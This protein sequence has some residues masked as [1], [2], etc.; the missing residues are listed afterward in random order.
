MNELPSESYLFLC[1]R[2]G[3]GFRRWNR[4]GFFFWGEVCL[5]LKCWFRNW[6]SSLRDFYKTCTDTCLR[7]IKTAC[8]S[9]AFPVHIFHA[10]NDHQTWGDDSW[11]MREKIG[12]VFLK[13]VFLALLRLTLRVHNKCNIYDGNVSGFPVG[14]RA[15][16]LFVGCW[17]AMM[18]PFACCWHKPRWN[19]WPRVKKCHVLY[20]NCLNPEGI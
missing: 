5:F 1:L 2:A 10:Q 19:Y 20:F 15:A 12:L 7:I 4:W 9:N 11:R 13:I 6:Q 17:E 8:T 3:L 16:E 14:V 18:H